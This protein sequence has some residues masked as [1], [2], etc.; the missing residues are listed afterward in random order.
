MTTSALIARH[1]RA[2]YFGGSWCET[3][4]RDLLA[5]I[6]WEQATTSVHRFNTIA[7]L[8][9]HLTYYVE[10]VTQVLEGGPLEARDKFSFD[11]PPIGSQKDWDDLLNWQWRVVQK[12]AT[13]VEQ[14]P[15]SRLADTFVHE[16]YSD[17]YYNLTGLVEHVHYH[18]GQI[19]MI[20]RLLPVG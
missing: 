20:K 1:F 5:D 8:V 7:T 17:Y 12:F 18:L 15:D 16:D 19:V 3:N 13:S 4:M 11:C 14:F 9:Y 10:G 2:A 6:T